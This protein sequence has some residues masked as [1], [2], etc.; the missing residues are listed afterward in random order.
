[1][2]KLYSET[3][4]NYLHVDVSYYILSMQLLC[5]IVFNRNLK[6]GEIGKKNKENLK[7]RASS[8]SFKLSFFVKLVIF[9]KEDEL[10]S[11][12]LKRP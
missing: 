2:V 1:M 7:A 10:K 12:N 11:R 5:L 6:I 8:T 9:A 3:A 4:S